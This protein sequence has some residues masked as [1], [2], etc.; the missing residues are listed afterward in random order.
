MTHLRNMS[1]RIRP[2][3]LHWPTCVSGSA[4]GLV[5]TKLSLFRK[6]TEM[7]NTFM[8]EDRTGNVYF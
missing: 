8:G 5:R 3:P 2:I 7:A 4:C 1:Q 6:L